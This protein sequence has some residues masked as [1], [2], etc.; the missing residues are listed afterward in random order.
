MRILSTSSNLVMEA[1]RPAHGPREGADCV[2]YYHQTIVEDEGEELPSAEQNGAPNT[3]REATGT[4]SYIDHTSFLRGVYPTQPSRY[5][6]SLI[7][8]HRWTFYRAFDHA[9]VFEKGATN[10]ASKGSEVIRSEIAISVPSRYAV[11]LVAA[12]S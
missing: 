11:E 12:F 6:Y 5:I 1:E 2:F 9:G 10:T 4:H 7:L 8:T 3:S